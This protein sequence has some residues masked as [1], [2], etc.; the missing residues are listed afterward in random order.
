ML[1]RVGSSTSDAILIMFAAVILVLL[2]A[3]ANIGNLSLAQ[4]VR[5]Q[6][7]ITVRRALGAGTS[8]LIRQCLTERVL[9]G[10]LGGAL[11]LALGDG[12]LEAFRSRSPG[13]FPCVAVV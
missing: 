12:G 7:E 9:L 4:A 13:T 3:C 10:A 11:V 1:T 8:R 6:G 5:R 2:I